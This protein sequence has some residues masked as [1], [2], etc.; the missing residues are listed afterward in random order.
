MFDTKLVDILIFLPKMILQD[1]T[2]RDGVMLIVV[3]V[4]SMF[5]LVLIYKVY[6]NIPDFKTRI[7]VTLQLA[8]HYGCYV[9]MYYFNDQIKVVHDH[10]AMAYGA[11]IC[12][13]AIITTKMIV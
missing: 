10:G 4:G 2:L 12:L 1:Y 5:S 3:Y 6:Q 9:L 13:Y 7:V 8:Q 11:V